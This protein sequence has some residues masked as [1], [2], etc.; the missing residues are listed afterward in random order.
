MKTAILALQRYEK[1]IYEWIDYHLYKI[2]FDHIFILD[3]NDDEDP[4]VVYNDRVT[5]YK[6]NLNCNAFYTARQ[7]DLYNEH[8]DKIYELGY[9]WLAV[10]DIDEYLDFYGKTV[11]EY[12][13]YR[14][15]NEGYN[16]IEIPWVMYSDNNILINEKQQ[17]ISTY[18]NETNRKRIE[19]NRDIFSWG[20]TIFKLDDGIRMSEQPHWINDHEY[21]NGEATKRL[22]ENENIAKVRHYI[23]KSLNDYL[24]KVKY[25]KLRNVPQTLVGK[26]IVNTYFMYN[27]LSLKKI[28]AFET[29]AKLKDIELTSQE[30]QDLLNLKNKIIN[31][32]V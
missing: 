7:L 30:K 1:D 11:Q 18:K 23:T 16:T 22:H 5:V 2:G 15:E 4:L 27:K 32:F 12:I 9:D 31:N 24:D 8:F 21:S 3:D 28:E 26:G 20:K 19:W 29:L 17:P 6:V 14:Y 13:S 10:I 25:K